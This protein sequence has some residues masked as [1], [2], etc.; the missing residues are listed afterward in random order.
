MLESDWS[1]GACYF[2]HGLFYPLMFMLP[3]NRSGFYSNGSYSGT[4]MANASYNPRF[5]RQIVV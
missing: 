4:C 2:Q 3:L 1:E 5:K